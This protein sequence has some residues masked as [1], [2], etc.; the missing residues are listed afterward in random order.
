M[1]NLNDLMQLMN[2]GNNPQTIMQN[3][4][5]QNPQV[6]VVLNQMQ[7]SGMTPQQFVMQYAK[8]NNIDIT[9]MVNMLNQRGI[10]L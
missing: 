6:Q 8:Q 10:K 5:K 2:M 9:P 4:A 3:M 1:N 7:S